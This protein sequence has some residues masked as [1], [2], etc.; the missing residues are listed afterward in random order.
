MT[1]NREL[2]DG[3]LLDATFKII[4]NAVALIMNLSICNVGVPV[5]LAFGP[6]EDI[7]FYE[8]FH[9]VFMPLFEIDLRGYRVV[10]DQG[11]ALHAVC[12]RHDRPQFFCLRHVLVNLKRKLFSEEVGNLVR[13]GVQGDYNGLCEAYTHISA[14]AEGSDTH[15]LFRTLAK[16]GLAFES[17]EIRQSAPDLWESVSMMTRVMRR[18]P[19]TSK[20]LESAH[21][22]ANE[23]TPRRNA[24]LASIQRVGAMM[25]QKVCCSLMLSSITFVQWSSKLAVALS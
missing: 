21:G 6:V 18:L 19:S 25:N 16:V 22:H 13:C 1:Q 5:A 4:P 10:C 11:S 9:R 7:N 23:D 14:A 24:L 8:T 12:E 15:Q 20:A 3:L 2:I 17:G